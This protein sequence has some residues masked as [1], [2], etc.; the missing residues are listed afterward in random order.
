[1]PPCVWGRKSVNSGVCLPVCER[2]NEAKSASHSPIKRDNEA[3]STSHVIP[4]SL[5]VVVAVSLYN[6][7]FCS[8]FK[9]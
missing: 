1:M 3:K 6:S 4:V 7:A 2:D 9:R 8:G 5:L